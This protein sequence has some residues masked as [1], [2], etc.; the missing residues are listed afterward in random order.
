MEYL[1]TVTTHVPDGTP[2]AAVEDIRAREAAHSRE[3]A[4]SDP[5]VS[6]AWPAV[7]PGRAG[8]EANLMVDRV[9]RRGV[10]RG[11][12]VSWASSRPTGA[13]TSS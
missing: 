12:P 2:E 9:H 4:A 10:H 7:S 13:W 1:V 8:R 3:L 6:R 11:A 5:G